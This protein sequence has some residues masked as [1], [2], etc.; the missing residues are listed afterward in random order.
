MEIKITKSTTLKEKYDESTLGFGKYFTDHMFVMDY[1]EGTGWHSPEIVPYRSIELDPAA[2]VLHYG[3]AIFEGLKA[4]RTADGQVQLFRPDANFNRMNASCDRMC[5]PNLDVDF[6]VEALKALIE[7]DESW[8]PSSQDT[9]LYIRPFMIAT[10]AIMGVRAASEYKFMIILS[11]S[12]PYYSEG[13]NP[14]KIHVEQEYVRAVRGGVGYAKAAGNYAA[15]MKAQKNAAENGFAQVLWLDGVERKYI[16]EVG[17]MNLFVKMG[18]K[19]YTPELTG[20]ILAGVTRNSVM[21]LLASKGLE[22]EERRISIQ[23]IYDAAENGLLEEIFGTGTAA[24]ISPVGALDWDGKLIQINGGEFG[25]VARDLY[26]TLTG[27]QNGS[28]EDEFGWVVPVK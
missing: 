14:V 28:K 7:V 5:M 27:I 18:G 4:Y 2:M 6:V 24:V 1:T 22:V 8:V 20:S 16:E 13:V 15:G 26:E 19:V 11:P 12:G 25:P 3:Q 9:S 23:E 17:A 21:Q 10:E